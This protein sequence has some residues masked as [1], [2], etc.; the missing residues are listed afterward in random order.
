MGSMRSQAATSLEDGTARDLGA[1]RAV[2]A[3][4]SLDVIARLADLGRLQSAGRNDDAR[5]PTGQPAIDYVRA[6][7]Q[8]GC[9][10]VTANKGPVAVAYEELDA[11]AN[12]RGCSSCSKER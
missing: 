3:D 6:A 1:K 5:R 9:D 10:V 12:D 4:G 2:P 7:L 11:L 8:C